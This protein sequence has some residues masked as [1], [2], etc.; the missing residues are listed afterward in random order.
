MSD[1]DIRY[2]LQHQLAE[3]ERES[4]RLENAIRSS[5]NSINEYK[6]QLENLRVHMLS[7]KGTLREFEKEQGVTY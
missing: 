6:K 4:E 5:E 1:G 7:L 2:Y 3:L